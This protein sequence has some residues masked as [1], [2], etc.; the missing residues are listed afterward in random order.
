MK[1]LVVISFITLYLLSLTNTFIQCMFLKDIVYLK[2]Y[3]IKL[4]IYLLQNQS[5]HDINIQNLI[6]LNPIQQT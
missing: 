3:Y 5:I 2:R 1:V 6:A 4:K